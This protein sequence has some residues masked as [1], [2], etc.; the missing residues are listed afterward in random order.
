MTQKNSLAADIGAWR[1]QARDEG[2]SPVVLL[3]LAR[4]HLRNVEQLTKAAEQAEI[5]QLYRLGLGLPLFDYAS[6][7]MDG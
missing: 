7:R 2:L 3:K 5:E 1:K 4:E 6:G